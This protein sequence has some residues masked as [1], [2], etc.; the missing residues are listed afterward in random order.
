MS[1]DV[2]DMEELTMFVEDCFS[3]FSPPL[4]PQEHLAVE[5]RAKREVDEIFKQRVESKGA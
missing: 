1:G 5:R 3:G 4:T 2:E